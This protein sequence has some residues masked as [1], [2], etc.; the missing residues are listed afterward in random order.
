LGYNL[1][2]WNLDERCLSFSQAKGLLAGSSSLV[3]IH[4]SQMSSTLS[5]GEKSDLWSFYQDGLAVDVNSI[6][7]AQELTENYA[8]KLLKNKE[9]ADSVKIKTLLWPTLSFHL[10]ALKIKKARNKNSH[11][12]LRGQFLLGFFDPFVRKLERFDTFNSLLDGVAKDL[13]R[14]SQKMN[15][16]FS[17]K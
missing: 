5:R 12:S 16:R 17:R 9:I 6:K 1:A 10:R 11:F 13:K 2:P 3:F 4:Y 15:L 8:K 7:L 14:I